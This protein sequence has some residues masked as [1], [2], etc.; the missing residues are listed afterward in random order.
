[1]KVAITLILISFAFAPP[2]SAAQSGTGI[3]GTININLEGSNGKQNLSIPVQILLFLTLLTFLP[4]ILVSITCFTR[5]VVVFHF[6]RQALG[7]METP[8]NQ[9]VLGLTLFLTFFVMSPVIEEINQK[10]LQPMTAGTITQSEALDR[11]IKPLRGF[12]MKYT[13]EKDYALFLSIAKKPRPRTPDDIPTMVVIPAFMISELKT[14]FQIG[15]VL[16]LPFLII[17]MVVATVLLS[18]G[19][20]QLP[21]VMVSMPFKILL[22]IMV[23]GWNLV[24]GSLVRS[25]YV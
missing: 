12:M 14:A 11:A 5:M 21:P 1:M 25:F 19:M 15:F 3:P 20:M 18:M 8:S 7:T 22:F 16:F 13:R 17:D 6:L 24:V 2:L 9:V 23:D 4:A 10:A